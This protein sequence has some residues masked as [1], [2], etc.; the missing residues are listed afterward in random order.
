MELF[1]T[2]TRMLWRHLSWWPAVASFDT[3]STAMFV[4]SAPP[5][6]PRRA[7]MMH[8]HAA[9]SGQFARAHGNAEFEAPSPLDLVVYIVTNHDAGWADFDRDPVT[10][11][12]TGL[13]S[14]VFGT[15]AP[16]IL[17]TSR[18]SADYN[19]P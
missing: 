17:S 2:F 3:G 8:D 7:I 14:T 5:G 13:P 9:L 11:P 12:Q 15:P 19:Q 1:L 18:G 10:D 16:H 6:R 4:Q